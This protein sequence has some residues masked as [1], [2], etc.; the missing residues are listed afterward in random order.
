MQKQTITLIGM[1]ACGKSTVGVLLAKTLG[2]AFI[3][4]DLLIQQ[5]TG[6]LLADI[7][8][9]DGIEAFLRIEAAALL[10]VDAAGAVIATGGSAVYS[11][12]GMA[13]L[14][15]S[16]SVVFLD[17]PPEEA[18]RRIADITARGV[19]ARA[20]Q[21]IADLY[22]ERLPLYQKWADSTFAVSGKTTEQLV[23]EIAEFA[24]GDLS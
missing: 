20:G 22:A 21:S 3:D 10:A 1:P 8:A 18:A 9:A 11:H 23:Q 5:R 13:H 4:T 6:R 16:G 2:L 17:I 15:A 24:R 7:L 12:A 19:V 14:K